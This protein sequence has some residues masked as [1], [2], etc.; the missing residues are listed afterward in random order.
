MDKFITGD[1]KHY[2]R[3]NLNGSKINADPP[4]D[5]EFGM[6]MGKRTIEKF[7][8]FAPHPLPH[9]DVGCGIEFSRR[10]MPE[11]QTTTCDLDVKRFPHQSD[12]FKTIT[13]F[14]V[15]EHLYN[16][17]FHLAEIKR[18]LAPNGKLYLTTPNDWSLIYRIEHARGRK[19]AP[20]FHQFTEF[21][22]RQI[23]ARAGFS[24]IHLSKY[25]RGGSGTIARLSQ[26]L[27]FVIAMVGE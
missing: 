18:V 8:S 14:E 21:D 10:Y 3:Y 13:S 12:T 27:F 20:H 25:R 4:V 1:R 2:G 26:N 7:L 5:P 23:M 6:R 15:L 19:Y 16:P 24:I 17:L 11:A 9:L 22:L